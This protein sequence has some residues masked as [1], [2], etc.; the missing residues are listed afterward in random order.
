MGVFNHLKQ[1]QRETN[2]NRRLREYLP[3]GL[4]ATLIC[5]T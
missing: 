5:V 1:P 2:L 4:D 3:F